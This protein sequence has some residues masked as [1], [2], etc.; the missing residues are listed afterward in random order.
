[1]GT[2]DSGVLCLLQQSEAQR[3]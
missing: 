3:R 1:M 2:Y